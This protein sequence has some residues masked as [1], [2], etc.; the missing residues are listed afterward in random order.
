MKPVLLYGSGTLSRLARQLVVE[1]GG[2]FAGYIDD[3]KTGPDI[4]GTF[5]QIRRVCPPDRYD[6]AIGIGYGDLEARWSVYEAVVAAGYDTP[7]LV[8]PTSMVGENARLGKGCFVMRGAVVDTGASVGDLAV[9]WPGSVLNHDSTVGPNTFVSP[10]ATICG[11]VTIG[12]HC[13]IGAGAIIINENEVP[14]RS[15]VKAGKVYF[16]HKPDFPW[17]RR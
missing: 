8:H 12:R 16:E 3:Y 13:F 5:E 6:A 1:C 14:D 11:F 17:A 10:N 4:V 2:R 9:L 15:F 7:S